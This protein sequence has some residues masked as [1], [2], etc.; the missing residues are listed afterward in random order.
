MARYIFL[1]ICF[2]C[3]I[4]S[5]NFLLAQEFLVKGKIIDALTQE[6]LNG[7]IIK[8]AQIGTTANSIGE[9]ALKV[10]SIHA[11]SDILTITYVGYDEKQISLKQININLP[12]LIAL[13]PS[14]NILT[15]TL[16]TASRYEQSVKRMM[17]ST[18]II[19]PYLIQ[20]K[21]T[22]M[23]DKFLDQVPSVN[24]VDG[25]V[26]IRS[27]SGWTYGAGSRVMV[28]VD[29]MPF[30][31]GDAGNVKWNFVPIE[32]VKQVEVVKGASSVLYGSSAL[33]GIV[34]FR[35][36]LTN[37]EPVTRF[38]TFSALYSNPQRQNLK[39][40]Q[41]P[42]KQYGASAF[43]TGKRNQLQYAISGNYLRDEGY[44]L[45]EN[46][47][48]LRM[49]SNLKWSTKNK[50]QFGLNLGM[51]FSNG[52]SFLLWE[53]Y[54]KG[55]TILDSQVTTTRSNNYYIDPFLTFY[56]GSFKHHVR[57]RLMYIANDLTNPDPTINQDN[58]SSNVYAEYQVQRYV[59]AIKLNITS[60]LLSNSN[61]SNSPLYNG[62]Q[63]SKNY[64]AFV[65][66][67]QTV[68]P[69]L[70]LSAGAR[71][72]YFDMNGKS[73]SKPV[74]RAGA[75]YEL[76]KASFIRSSFGMGYRFPSIAERHIET[77]VG[78]LNIFPNPNLES[79]TGWN[80]ELGFKQ[81]F[82]FKGF[83][84][85]I[86]LAYFHTQYQNMI[87]FNLGLWR[88]YDPV[89]PFKSFG[90]TSLNVGETKISGFDVSLNAEGSW[91]V[92]KFQTLFGYTYT[93]PIM[94]H[95]DEVFASDS[96]GI[97]YSFRST[98][99][100]STN[101]LKYRY[102]HLLKWDFQLSY[103]KW[104]L[105]YSI[106]YNSFMENIDAAFVQL[107]LNLFAK[108]IDKARAANPNGNTV[109]DARIAYQINRR[110]KIAL[111]VNNLLNVE[112]MTRPADLRPPRLSM[113][114][115]NYAF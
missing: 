48:R 70:N 3:S 96:L 100:D 51:L 85:F 10:P 26:N 57:G 44:R 98:R 39:W 54:D 87:D 20:G 40:S 88:S 105:G 62:F 78:L 75:N 107:P 43:H 82:S 56:T 89:N 27:G 50:V 60:G 101:T 4:L 71:Y 22:T 74:Y 41:N 58:S 59:T 42:L 81:G 24:V 47:H 30:L 111:M 13:N 108:D 76:A 21:N 113:V 52:A 102:K 15:Q 28:L 33:S 80:A 69:K 104:Q 12:I 90:F 16:V 35:T 65:Q 84:G 1:F 45:G 19:K 25:Q 91:G 7:A 9:F 93:N 77:S 5:A 46:D 18:E 72:E 103:N 109:M 6:P 14:E 36:E 67:D 17:V 68:T 79:E 66:L 114:Q 11:S 97:Q 8:Y 115:F 63:Q 95:I 61:Q 99:S 94:I 2:L 112:F 55:Y 38:S 86:D 110:M 34:H 23:M 64:A 37:D 49:N 106:K 31:T 32:N 29:D 83:K 92:F 53:S 73:E